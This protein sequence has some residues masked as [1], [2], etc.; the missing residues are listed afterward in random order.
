MLPKFRVTTHPGTILQ[1]EF[2]D[3]M[4]LTQ[5]A[6]ARDL[7]IPLNRVNEWCEGSEGSRRSLHCCWRSTSRTRQSSG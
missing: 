3:P 4:G 7:R 1:E 5:A 2:L 6:L